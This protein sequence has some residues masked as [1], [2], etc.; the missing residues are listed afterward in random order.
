MT[1][2][3]VETVTTYAD[4]SELNTKATLLVYILKC[5]NRRDAARRLPMLTGKRKIL[6][7]WN[8]KIDAAKAKLASMCE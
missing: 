1:D 5:V 6:A 3:T 7:A 8:A 2:R 4:L